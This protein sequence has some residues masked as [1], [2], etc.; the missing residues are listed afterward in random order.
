MNWTKKLS[1]KS[2]N[3]TIVPVMTKGS[4]N[5]RRWMSFT[6]QFRKDVQRAIPEA[7][8]VYYMNK[9]H[10]KMRVYFSKFGRVGSG[11]FVPI[12]V[13]KLMNLVDRDGISG[14]AV[15]PFMLEQVMKKC[16][17]YIEEEQK[18]AE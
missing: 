10:T 3:G 17:K 15:K 1:K 5:W 9:E 2:V 14:T 8:E 6:L 13:V 4:N 11:E 18:D 16:K 7:S 12:D